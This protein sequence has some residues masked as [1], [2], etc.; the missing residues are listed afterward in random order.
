MRRNGMEQPLEELE[1]DEI[2]EGKKKSS[3]STTRKK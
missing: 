3:H 1:V 2:I